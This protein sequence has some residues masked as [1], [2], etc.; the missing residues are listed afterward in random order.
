MKGLLS[1]FHLNGHTLECDQNLEP[2]KKQYH[3]KVSLSFEWS[4][5]GVTATNACMF[6]IHMG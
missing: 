3:M 4:H 5:T 2:R 1:S 6:V